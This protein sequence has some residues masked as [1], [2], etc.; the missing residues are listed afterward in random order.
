MRTTSYVQNS[1]T[2][3]F[4][5][6]TKVVT[7][8]FTDWQFTRFFMNA[9]AGYPYFYIEKNPTY[10]K[11]AA[12]FGA[13][14]NGGMLG[15]LGSDSLAGQPRMLTAYLSG[16][17]GTNFINQNGSGTSLLLDN[18]TG[19]LSTGITNGIIDIL[20]VADGQ[21]AE[22]IMFDRLLTTAQY[23]IVEGY[24]SRKWFL[25]GSSTTVVP[26]SP[27]SI[28]GCQLWLD[29]AD[30]STLTKQG[31]CI[32]WRQRGNTI[33]SPDRADLANPSLFQPCTNCTTAAANF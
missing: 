27:I 19:G 12:V 11:Y 22:M 30:T 8:S 33:S 6:V 13:Y 16:N 7:A 14:G 4:F 5:V 3:T 28:S 23:Q 29:A 26:F 2:A 9:T 24:L 25:A 1:S 10:E 20:G 32:K 31:T 21:M 17:S 18:T 15:D